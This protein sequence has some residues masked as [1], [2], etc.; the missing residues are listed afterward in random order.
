MNLKFTPM[1]E[2]LATEATSDVDKSMDAIEADSAARYIFTSGSTGDPKAVIYTQRMMCSLIGKSGGLPRSGKTGEQP[3]RILDWMPW[4]HTG[5]GVMRVNSVIARGGAIYFDT[6]RPVPGEYEQ[7]LRNLREVRP[8]ALAGAPVGYA[9]LADALE[10]DEALNAIVFQSA[11]SIN[12]GSAAMSAAL[13]ERLQALCVKATGKRF[14][15]S[16]GLASTEVIGCTTA[17][18]LVDDPKNIGLPLPGITLKLIPNLGKLELRVKG[19]TVTPGYF[20]DPQLTQASF[21]EEGFFKMGDAVRFIDPDVPEKGLAFDG[22]I[23][24]QFKLSTGTWVSAG[25][26]RTEIVSTA[27]PYVRDV[28]ICGLNQSFLSVMLWPNMEACAQFLGID[29]SADLN[30]TS[31][32]VVDSPQVVDLI[33]RALQ[34]HNRKNPTSSTKI[35]RF[36]LLA[37]PPSIDGQEITEKGY[38]NQRAILERRKDVADLLYHAERQPGVHDV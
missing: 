16:P 38:V 21:D 5:A 3:A 27:S 12:F 1:A 20:R 17:Y 9:M 15:T 2:V 34:Q 10:S 7:T 19:D 36:L 26:L 13:Y 4:S 37:Q 8:T 32:R 29:E 14:L 24:E 6:G 25:T 35:D 33:R 11:S 23:A 30:A 28:V 22:R 18:W 31:A